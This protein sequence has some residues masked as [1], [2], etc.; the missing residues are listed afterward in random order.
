MS[1]ASVSDINI[2]PPPSGKFPASEIA[3]LAVNDVLFNDWESIWLQ[4]R[5]NDA[6]AYFRFI[7]AE[8]SPPP[9]DWTLLQFKPGDNCTVTLGGQPALSGLITD[10]QTAY[11]ATRHQVQLIGKSLTHWGYKSSVDSP[12]GSFDGMNLE[13]VFTQILSKYPGTPKIIGLV[14]PLPFQKLQN[15]PGELNWDFLERIARPRGAVLGADNFGNYLLIGQ[16]AYPVLAQ[17]KEGVNIKACECIISHDDFF[18][19]FKVTAQTA[20]DD[21]QYG[22]AANELKCIVAGKAEVTSMLITPAEQPVKSQAEV[23]DRAYNEAKWHAGTEVVANIVV[24]GWT[25]DGT[26]L[27]EAGQMVYV[28]T[29]MAMLNMVMKV[30]TVTFE[31]NDRAGTQTTLELVAP[32]LLN[33]DGNW[34]PGG[35]G[36]PTAPTPNPGGTPQPPPQIPD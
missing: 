28:D 36:V 11:D 18:Q 15:Q 12:S 30:R 5:W 17:L 27:W 8:R 35:Q 4:Y 26:H 3:T 25:S 33:D 1:L 20:G 32:W 21:Q 23:C 34:N 6:F 19:D 29:P 10:R 7:A 9:S 13:Q 22:A 31:Q 2:P 14:N 16:H 24:Y